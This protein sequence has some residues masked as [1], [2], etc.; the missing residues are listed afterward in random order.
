MSDTIAM[1]PD[2]GF[3]DEATIYRGHNNVAYV[4]AHWRDWMRP[5]ITVYA[6]VPAVEVTVIAVADP[7]TYTSPS[8]QV[9]RRVTEAQRVVW[10]AESGWGADR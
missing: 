2:F 1:H 8:A 9:L 6:N 3:T 10:S 5:G 7:P 4:G